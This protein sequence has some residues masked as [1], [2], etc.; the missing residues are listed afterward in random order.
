MASSNRLNHQNQGNRN[1]ICPKF[2]DGN[3]ACTSFPIDQPCPSKLE[4]MIQKSMAYENKTISDQL[5]QSNKPDPSRQGSDFIQVSQNHKHSPQQIT[6]RNVYDQDSNI[7]PN[8]V[9]ENRYESE[10]QCMKS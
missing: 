3:D 4:V 10:L 8:I 2:N 6:G 9:T 5:E 7:Q 1:I